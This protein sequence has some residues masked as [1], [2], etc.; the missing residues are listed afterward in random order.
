MVSFPIL[1]F[2]FP[3][4]RR[5]LSFV[6]FMGTMPIQGHLT[7]AGWSTGV[8][9]GNWF[10]LLPDSSSLDF[11][12]THFPVIR[13]PLACQFCGSLLGC[14]WTSV[15]TSGAILCCQQEGTQFLI[16]ALL[17]PFVTISQ[18]QFP[19]PLLYI[20]TWVLHDEQMHL[21]MTFCLCLSSGAITLYLSSGAEGL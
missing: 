10:L 9:G 1:P 21:R 5:S 7:V 18:H 16:S 13:F 4:A 2:R 20:A 8:C 12:M 11:G 17:L 3:Q 14:T 6:R 19:V 15:N